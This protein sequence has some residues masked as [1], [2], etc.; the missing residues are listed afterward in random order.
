MVRVQ[1]HVREEVP[2]VAIEDD[3]DECEDEVDDDG[4]VEE[5]EDDLVVLLAGLLGHRRQ[6]EH[7]GPDDREQYRDICPRHSE[8]GHGRVEAGAQLAHKCKHDDLEEN[9][10]DLSVKQNDG[11]PDTLS[12]TL[13]NLNHFPFNRRRKSR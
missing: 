5:T 1:I 8:A 13:L 7:G 6:N 4:L 11:V 12:K 2:G 9:P 10:G 3:D